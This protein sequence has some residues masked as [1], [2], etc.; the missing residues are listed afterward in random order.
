MSNDKK[1]HFRV[2]TPQLLKE[3]ADAGLVQNAGVLFIPLNVLKSFLSQVADRCSEINDPILNRL[4]FDMNLYELPSP[5]TKEYND[6]MNILYK[7]EKEYLKSK[8]Q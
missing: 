5:T 7:K 4:M 8:Q 3:I 6:I 2:D 1:M